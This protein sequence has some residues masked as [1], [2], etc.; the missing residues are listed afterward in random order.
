[1]QIVDCVHF[2]SKDTGPKKF[3]L[4]LVFS[5]NIKAKQKRAKSVYQLGT[6]N[7]HWRLNICTKPS[8]DN[9]I[10]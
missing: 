7:H 3:R 1:M 6:S 8:K 4:I 2:V 5:Y 9:L 10:H